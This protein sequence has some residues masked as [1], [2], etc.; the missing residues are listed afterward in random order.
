MQLIFTAA[1]RY[2]ITVLKKWGKNCEIRQRYSKI[3]AISDSCQSAGNFYGY[4]SVADD[5]RVYLAEEQIQP[6]Q[7]DYH[8]GPSV[9]GRQWIV[10]RMDFSEKL[11]ARRSE[12]A[13]GI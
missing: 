10:Q 4:P 3:L 2:N 5:F 12:T 7:L 13:T 11:P 9:G 6:G 1:M 8:S